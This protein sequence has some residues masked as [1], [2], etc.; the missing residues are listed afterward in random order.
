[1]RAVL[2]LLALLAS[3]VLGH[4]AP[5]AIPAAKKTAEDYLRAVERLADLLARVNDEK[6][7]TDAKPKI[8]DLSAESRDA[9]GQ[10]FAALATAD[11]PDEKV[12]AAL[13]KLTERA[14]AAA[15]RIGR[16]FD[17]IAADHKP[18][19][20]VLNDTKLFAELMS[21]R[22]AKAAEQARELVGSVRVFSQMNNGKRV[23]NLSDIAPTPE[24]AKKYL[25]DPWGFPF[26]YRADEK[27]VYVW[28]VSPYSGKNLGSPPP[29]EK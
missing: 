16:E 8:D 11:A 10:V 20:K 19:F 14:T 6:S 25:L 17:R 28:T 7:A 18:A 3:A 22:E 21:A 13:G 1:M 26:Q 5:P 4:A 29:D 23:T 24:A 15:D 27:R 2:S 12:A 9:R